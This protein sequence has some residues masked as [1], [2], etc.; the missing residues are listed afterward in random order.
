VQVNPPSSIMPKITYFSSRSK[1][2]LNKGNLS[3]LAMVGFKGSKI[4]NAFISQ[5]DDPNKPVANNAMIMMSSHSVTP[6][7][8]TAVFKHFV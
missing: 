5:I 8:P 6:I 1:K 4:I 3:K 2:K 7:S